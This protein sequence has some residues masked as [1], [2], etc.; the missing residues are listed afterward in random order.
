MITKLII[1]CIFVFLAGF[2]DSIAGGGGLISL[3]AFMFV[4]MPVHN[5]M[6]CNKFAG[7]VG[8]TLSAVKFFKS[9]AMHLKVALVSA[10]GA[11]LASFL[12]T[13]LTLLIDEKYLKIFLIIAL[14][15]IAMFL[16]FKKDF[17]EKEIDFSPKKLYLISL[18]IG[19][20]V[21]FYDGFVGAGTGTFA[22]IAYSMFL[23]FDLKTSSG[24]AKILNLA[25]NY[26]SMLTFL[27]NGKV[28]FYFAIPAA[29]AGLLGNYIGSH[30]A[31]K[32]GNKFIKPV[33][34]FVICILF[35][36]ILFDFLK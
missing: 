17:E 30:F 1:L 35:V 15:L 2:I 27:F 31:I 6:A 36:K 18:A 32:K 21:G 4:G 24:N 14:P 34:I 5:A 33:M 3:P 13:R 22:I 12:G 8:T 10:V 11:F 29:F 16:I 7:S 26:A 9:K 25:S 20:V 23:K 28:L 19:S